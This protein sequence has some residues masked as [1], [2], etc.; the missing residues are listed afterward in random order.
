[1]LKIAGFLLAALMLVAGCTAKPIYNAENR[2]IPLSAQQFPLERIETLLIQAGQKRN[3]KFT[4]EA[5][6]HLSGG[7]GPAEAYSAIVDI[8]FDQKTYRII[9]RSSAGLEARNGTI[10]RAYNNWIHF[11]ERDIDS[12]LANASLTGAGQS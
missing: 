8:Y 10:H 6:G 9:Y 3:W 5:L 11:L 4:R 7:A 1:M 12:T 2:Q